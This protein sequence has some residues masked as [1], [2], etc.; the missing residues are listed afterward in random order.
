MPASD[1]DELPKP[2]VEA[3]VAA[4]RHRVTALENR[5]QELEQ[6]IEE[7]AK[8]GDKNNG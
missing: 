4:L 1:V 5:V 6:Q 8:E 3:Q 7:L 2:R